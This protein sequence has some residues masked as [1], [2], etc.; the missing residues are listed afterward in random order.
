MEKVGIGVLSH[1]HGHVNTYCNEMKDYPDV[2]LIATWDDNEERGRSASEAYGLEF[3]RTPEEV[4]S[5]PNVDAVIISSE[6]NRHADLV[7]LATSHGKHILCQKP[8]ATT[9][10]DC[11][12]I[13]AAVENS[14]VKFSM[15]FQMR[16]D[17]VNQ[18]IR[19][20]VHEGAVGRI[21]MVRRRH[22]IGV[23]LNPDFVNGPTRWHIDPV[24]NVGMFFDDAAHPADWFLWIF[25]KP[26]SVMA[27]IDSVITDVSPDDNGAA[28]F[29]FDDGM[30]GVV[31]NS[32]TT[33]A[34]IATTEIYGD[35]GT[36]IQ[37][38]GDG[39]SS[40]AD[41]PE[42]LAPLRMIRKGETKWTGCDL[43]SPHDHGRR[44]A[45]IP[46][47]FIDYILGVSDESISACEGK[48]SVEMVIGA[49]ES[50]RS[51]TRVAFP[52]A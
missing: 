45:A 52:L 10:A 15:A 19:E 20:L 40:F 23:L 37:D 35:E 21:A 32:S 7:E 14:G 16:Q 5:D 18:K 17:P 46:R 41:R 27:E 26:V 47:P 38:W 2:E 42:G 4:V 43:P 11:D 12:R 36:I 31:L 25:G 39:V 3:R 48:A 51:G 30:M 50:A 9:L 13:I 44:I 8:M 29:R 33:V 28:I 49:Y 34:A 22:S 1:A 6:T 24:A